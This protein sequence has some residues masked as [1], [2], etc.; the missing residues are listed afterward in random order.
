VNECNFID[1]EVE[2]PEAYYLPE[3]GCEFLSVG[4]VRIIISFWEQGH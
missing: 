2:S 4:D 1:P 3:A